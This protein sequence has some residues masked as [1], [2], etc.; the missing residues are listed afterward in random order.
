LPS[1]ARRSHAPLHLR[2]SPSRRFFDVRA[3][4]PTFDFSRLSSPSPP[5]GE[6]QA[7]AAAG[8]FH[9]EGLCDPDLR[10]PLFK[11]FDSSGLSTVWARKC[12]PTDLTLLNRSAFASWLPG[13]SSALVNAPTRPSM[14]AL[15]VRAGYALSSKG[16]AGAVTLHTLA[17]PSDG[18][19][20]LGDGA[21]RSAISAPTLEICA[22]TLSVESGVSVNA[23]ASGFAAGSSY[24]VLSLSL[25]PSRSLSASRL[26]SL[27]ALSFLLVTVTVYANHAHNLTRS[28]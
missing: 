27:S 16:P 23:S 24:V 26:C 10:R 12:T 25:S 8:L 17:Q 3:K 11:G 5:G 15:T 20:Q 9:S 19:A 4:A 21:R 7:Q 22:D 14:F 6:A 2:T 1:P 28:P 18:A 13:R